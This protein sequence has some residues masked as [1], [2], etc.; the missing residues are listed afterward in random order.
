MRTIVVADAVMGLDNV[1]A[2][3]GA[4]HGSYALV[5]VGLLISVP[6]VVWGSSIVLK[7]VERFPAVVYLGAGVLVWTAVKDDERGK[8]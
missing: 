6:I 1:L 5:V 7:L 2:V 3:A 4:A 8:R